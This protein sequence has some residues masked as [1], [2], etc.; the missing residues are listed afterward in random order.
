MWLPYIES[1]KIIMEEFTRMWKIANSK[2][3]KIK[4]GPMKRWR[5][6]ADVIKL[7]INHMDWWRWMFQ[8]RISE[9]Q[10]HDRLL[11]IS[12]IQIPRYIAKQKHH[13]TLRVWESKQTQIN[14]WALIVCTYLLIKIL[15]W[16]QSIRRVILSETKKASTK[17]KLHTVT[18]SKV[19]NIFTLLFSPAK[20]YF[21]FFYLQFVLVLTLLLCLAV[22]SMAEPRPQ[23]KNRFSEIW[24]VNWR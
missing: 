10:C 1:V 23:C 5:E 3:M 12:F 19:T 7:K 18:M 8:F 16:N 20:L 4:I 6:I 24:I 2:E 14:T 21:D 11:L 9:F 13:Q 15:M 22:M 17:R